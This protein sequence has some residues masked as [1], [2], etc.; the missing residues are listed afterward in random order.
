MYE[1][2]TKL[3][4]SSLGLVGL[5]RQAKCLLAA[6]NALRLGDAKFAWILKPL[7]SS[8]ATL[9]A[10]A[11]DDDVEMSRWLSQ[12]DIE[13]VCIGC[14]VVLFTSEFRC[15]V[16]ASL[17]FQV[18]RNTAVVFSYSCVDYCTR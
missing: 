10:T 18:S 3:G 15:R 13:Q 1:Y 11:S 7:A 8:K 2:A 5:Q 17:I 14:S 9:I 12:T 16:F 4:S 6:I